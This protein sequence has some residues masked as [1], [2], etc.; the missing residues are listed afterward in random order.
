MPRQSVEFIAIG[1]RVT[2]VTTTGI[3]QAKLH[4]R[5]QPAFL[6]HVKLST[7]RATNRSRARPNTPR[8]DERDAMETACHLEPSMSL[9]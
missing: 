2:L 8:R 6:K 5:L 4:K 3:T 7:G 9:R 1:T